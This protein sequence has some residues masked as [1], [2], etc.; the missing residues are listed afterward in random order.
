METPGGR[1][2][3]RFIILTMLAAAIGIGSSGCATVS[4]AA[5]PTSAPS[6]A[7]MAGTVGAPVATPEGAIGLAMQTASTASARAASAAADVA[8]TD[9]SRAD[10]GR[11][12]AIA[13]ENATTCEATV[14]FQQ[15]GTLRVSVVHLMS[16]EQRTAAIPLGRDESLSTLVTLR[17]CPESTAYSLQDVKRGPGLTLRIAPTADRSYVIARR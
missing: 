11:T 9:N 13:L 6:V 14:R 8:A 2:R 5:D 7:A 4:R 10:D 16:M 3:A 1:T 17:G 12:V 15:N